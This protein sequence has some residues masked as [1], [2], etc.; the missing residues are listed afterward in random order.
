MEN[1]NDKYN[2]AVVVSG[3]D[4]EYQYNIICGINKFAK[5]H[6]INIS[7]FVAFGGM[8]GNKKSDI[9]EYNIYKLIDF[10]K[11]NGAILMTNTIND[12]NVKENV[13]QN[14]LKAK[15]PAV[16]FDC[17]DYPEFYNISIDNSKAMKNI[18]R[19]IITEHHAKVF[20]YIS[21]PLSNPEALARYQAFL[22][23]LDEYNLIAEKDRIFF[24]EFRSQDGRQAID[25]FYES[26]LPLPDAIICANDAMALTAM[27]ALE[28]LGFCVPEH[29]IITGFD[30]TYYARNYSPILTTVKRPLFTA[31]YKACG[32]LFDV[33][34]GKSPDKLT[35]LDALPIFSESCGCVSCEE[36]DFNS[37]KKRSYGRNESVRENISL[38]NRLTTSLA[39]TETDNEL[40]DAIEK[41]INELEC[42]KFSL[43][44]TD[45]WQDAFSNVM[46]IDPDAQ[47]SGFM[48][49][50]L[51]WDKG[52]RRSVGYFPSCKMYPE[53]LETGGNISYFLPI[54]FRDRTL[55]YYIIT[56]GDFSINSLFCYSFTMN[57][58]NAIENIRKL[59]HL[60]KAMNELDHLYS[61]DVLCGIY[62]RNG[63]IKRADEIFKESVINSQ[64]IMISFIDMD[65]LKH[66]N[67]NYGHTEG[68]L[69][70]QRLARIVNDCCLPTSIC[71][72]FG[73]DEFIILTRNAEDGEDIAIERKFF[74]ILQSRK[75]FLE[76][77]Y[78]LSASIGSVIVTANK[79]VTLY[80]VIKQ[81]DEKMYQLK[82]KN[83]MSRN[84]N[85]ENE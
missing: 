36:Q 2:I 29:V 67:D 56:N 12:T 23:V 37:F 22:E 35:M 78:E 61:Y 47:Y 5:E 43:C 25:S 58:S 55:G 69:A 59:F 41:F 39:E 77:P 45:D 79:D 30:C 44:L 83:R 80:S 18:V 72:R 27:A 62:N 46:P 4:E 3:I 81:A 54:H 71:A 6:D 64:K 53:D 74:N 15:I 33:F 19:H 24:G 1:Y 51:I 70:L 65:G 8:L 52:D 82:I 63:F 31:G 17:S 38:M 42:E 50:P 84:Y 21:G 68:D 9:G 48:T 85:K 73:G 10:S 11:F 14:V 7:Y 76:K 28:K 16:V 40:F 32:I 75:N 49:A 66:I 26:G 13:I 20:N 57:I 34:E 60:N